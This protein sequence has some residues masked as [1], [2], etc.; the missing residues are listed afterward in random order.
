MKAKKVK[1]M[2]G[3]AWQWKAGDLDFELAAIEDAAVFEQYQGYEGKVV[4]VAVLPRAEY[5]RLKAI[6]RRSKP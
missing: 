6:E 3:Y 5:R 4:A 2:N 1:A